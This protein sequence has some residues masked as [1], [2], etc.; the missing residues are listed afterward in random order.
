MLRENYM[1]HG[2]AMILIPWSIFCFLIIVLIKV[3]CFF[4]AEHKKRGTSGIRG[5]GRLNS[6][7]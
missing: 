1:T 4:F 6:Y 7:G 3:V 2:I 5:N